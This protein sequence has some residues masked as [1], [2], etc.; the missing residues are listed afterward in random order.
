[1]DSLPNNDLQATIH[2]TTDESDDIG[3]FTP[4]FFS[5]IFR[6]PIIAHR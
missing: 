5:Q 2:L 4:S 1:M 6:K 3:H